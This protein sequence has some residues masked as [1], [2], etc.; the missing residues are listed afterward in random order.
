MTKD[1]LI[2][3]LKMYMEISDDYMNEYPG[4]EVMDFNSKWKEE[5]SAI[6]KTWKREGKMELLRE[7]IG[8]VDGEENA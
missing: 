2:K 4:N 5:K 3:L 8:L 1:M 6:L 7:L